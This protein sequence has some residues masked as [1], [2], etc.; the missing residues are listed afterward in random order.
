MS[1]T[2]VSSS[3][4]IRRDD[5]PNGHKLP[6]GRCLVAISEVLELKVIRGPRMSR[7]YVQ[8]RDEDHC[9]E[10]MRKESL[11]TIEGVT[12]E[13]HEH[14]VTGVIRVIEKGINGPAGYPLRVTFMVREQTAPGV[15]GALAK[16]SKRK[17]TTLRL[18][19]E[20]KLLPRLFSNGLGRTK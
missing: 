6:T 7:V 20:G 9:L 14:T 3:T 18:R 8:T 13:G 11:V 12:A 17:R 19:G 4:R 2:T 5:K 15:E 1:G 10:A 16:T